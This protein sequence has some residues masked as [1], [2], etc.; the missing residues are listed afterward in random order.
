MSENKL[1]ILGSSSGLPQ[2]NRACSGYVLK[3]GD[4][5]SLI[6]CGGGVTSS[7]LRRG[8][9]PLDVDRVFISHT[10]P[11]HVTELPLFLQLLHLKK[12]SGLVSLYLPG[13]FVE[14]MRRYLPALYIIEDKLPF[15]LDMVGYDDG[16]VYD[17]AFKLRAIGNQHL[18]AYHDLIEENQL[19]NKMQCC[20]FD[21]EV[22]GKKVFYSSD[23]A[24][25]D[26]VRPHLDGKDVVILESTH[27][28]LDEFIEH[29]RAI[30]VGR[31]VVTHLGTDEEVS[32]IN[33]RISKAGLNNVETVVDGLEIAL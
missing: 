13:D 33:R 14:P 3:T 10:H 4:S 1:I 21:I 26:D 11:D 31:Y 19:S 20:S 2:A 17:E 15:E 30:K 28:S 25:Y 23:I 12:R 16:F 8:L 9:N 7:F 5:L 18:R 32:E 27:I 6:D 22:A 24:A 29:A